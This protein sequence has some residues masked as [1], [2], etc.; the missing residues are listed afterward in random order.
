MP[1]YTVQFW[2]HVKGDPP[3]V[4]MR[5]GP[6]EPFVIQAVDSTVA[7]LVALEELDEDGLI[8]LTPG[9]IG[10]DRVNKRWSNNPRPWLIARVLELRE[11]AC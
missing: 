3:H 5:Y 6:D 11:E 7:A 1:V 8:G 4:R 10:W 2:E 9:D